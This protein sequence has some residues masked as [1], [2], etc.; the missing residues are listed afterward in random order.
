MI[1]SERLV[2][3]ADV[4]SIATK[5][6]DFDDRLNSQTPY[7]YS[8]LLEVCTTFVINFTVIVFEFKLLKNDFK[9]F[10]LN[11]GIHKRVQTVAPNFFGLC[12]RLL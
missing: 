12:Y 4:K 10:K 9:G 3:K 11:H 7:I 1:S 2:Q 6:V 8:K 5:E